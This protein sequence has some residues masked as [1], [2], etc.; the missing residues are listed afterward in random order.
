LTA[1]RRS[2]DRAQAPAGVADTYRIRVGDYR[3]VYA[4][5]DVERLVVIARVGHRREVYRR[6]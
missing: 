3:L 6:R 1:W 5:Y 4:V 2:R